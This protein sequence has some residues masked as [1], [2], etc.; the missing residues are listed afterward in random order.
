MELKKLQGKKT[1]IVAVA[2]IC[3]ALGGAVAGFIE[4]NQAIMLILGSGLFA[5]LRAGLPIVKKVE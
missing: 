3:Y 2:T 5:G 1:Y 4:I